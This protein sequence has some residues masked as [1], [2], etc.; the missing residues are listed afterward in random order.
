MFT[1]YAKWPKAAFTFTGEVE[2]Y[3][4]RSFCPVC[5]SHLFN[6]HAADVEIRLGSLDDA[7]T[8]L[9]P[10]QEGWIVRR[11]HWLVAIPGVAQFEHDPDH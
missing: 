2:T 5:G 4:G 6:L 11:E 1:A 9:M 10:T 8:G 7:P 3:E